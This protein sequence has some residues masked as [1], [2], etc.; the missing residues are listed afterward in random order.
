MDTSQPA[1]AAAIVNPGHD[2][3]ER[4]RL[5]A[6]E[7]YELNSPVQDEMLK[8]IVQLAQTLMQAP[9]AAFSVIDKDRQY[10]TASVGLDT[11]E[12]PREQSFCAHAVNQ[13]A[14][15]VVNDATRD[16]RFQTN[17]LVTGEQHFRA[18]AGVPV[19]APNGVTVGALCAIDRRTREFSDFQLK[20]LDELGRVLEQALVLR[21]ISLTDPLTG[22]YNR[23]HLKQIMEREWRR[24]YRHLLPLSV[25]LLD[26]DHFKAYN[27]HY[28]HLAG[29]QCLKASANIVAQE[30]RRAAD[31]CVRFGG[32]EFL[33]LLPETPLQGARE[34][35]ERVVKGFR[36][37]A[38]TH[39]AAPS[40]IVTASVGAAVAE[41]LDDLSRGETQLLAAAD[42]ALYQ[43]KQAGRD[44]S[45]V[46]RLADT[47]TLQTQAS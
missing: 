29:D 7:E 45:V 10:F 30:A 37:A 40:G 36:D 44:R 16:H 5:I 1:A 8:H 25:I 21:S 18:Y 43:A 27:D 26:L 33:L 41:T 14:A 20:A 3:Q 9:I 46:L 24:A 13:K 28:G 11:R 42:R 6:L 38:M 15:L 17:L 47:V 2:A 32:E 39:P 22:L 23:R 4:A 19:R 34:I 35:A 12:T 31:I